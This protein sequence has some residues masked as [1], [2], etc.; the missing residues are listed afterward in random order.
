MG[1]KDA[2]A[3]KYADAYLTKYGDRITQVQ[4]KILSMKITNQKKFFFQHVLIVDVLVKPEK[5]KNITRCQYTKKRW[6]KE[7]EFMQL[8]QGHSVVIQGVKGKKGKDDSELISILNIMNLTTKKDLV[9][10]GQPQSQRIKRQMV[11]K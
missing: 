6:F 1:F 11:R 7:P 5:S 3:K 4:G 8:S 10:T 2:L 9:A